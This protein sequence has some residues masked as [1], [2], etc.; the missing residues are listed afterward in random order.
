MLTLLNRHQQAI[1][2]FRQGLAKN[3]VLDFGWIQL[4]VELNTLGAWP[5]M[6]QACKDGLRSTPGCVELKNNLGCA[7]L[8]LGQPTQALQ[9]F[10]EAISLQ[11]NASLY[12]YNKAKA[13]EAIGRR[14]EAQQCVAQ[15]QQLEKR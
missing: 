15:A 10:E 1:P 7:L 8:G 5:E 11:P 6:A 3:P 12:W 2:C 4:T 9:A 14:Q 13:L